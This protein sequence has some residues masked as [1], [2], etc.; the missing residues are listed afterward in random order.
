MKRMFIIYLLSL[1]FLFSSCNGQEGLRMEYAEGFKL[2][3][4]GMD[5]TYNWGLAIN[6]T[7]FIGADE[8]DGIIE[9]IIENGYK[10]VHG[11]LFGSLP[12]YYF[13]SARAWLI[14][15]WEFWASREEQ[16]ESAWNNSHNFD[17]IDIACDDSWPV[18]Y[19]I[20]RETDSFDNRTIN[21]IL[22]A[23]SATPSREITH[24]QLLSQFKSLFN[25]KIR[26][27]I[28]PTH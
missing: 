4:E 5:L 15:R 17:E 21:I 27:R 18:R 8:F 12:S 16:E 6:I 26:D 7:E 13:D 2:T 24:G 22:S 25:E 20:S 9:F 11:T 1:L 3:A 28:Y 10:H 19:S 23:N 14:P